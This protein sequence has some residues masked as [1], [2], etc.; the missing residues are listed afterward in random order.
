MPEIL[1]RLIGAGNY[2]GVK[3]E[4][5]TCQGGHD[6]ITKQFVLI[7]KQALNIKMAGRIRNATCK[8]ILKQACEQDRTSLLFK[9]AISHSS[10]NALP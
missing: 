7:H 2:D 1:D 5:K 8:L 3:A 9:L 4:N 6:R 10:L